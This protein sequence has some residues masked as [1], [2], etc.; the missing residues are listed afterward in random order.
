MKKIF[1]RSSGIVKMA[2]N[3]YASTAS[4]ASYMDRQL[5]TWCRRLGPSAMVQFFR[6]SNRSE[7][8]QIVATIYEGTVF[9]TSC[10]I[11]GNLVTAV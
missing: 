11:S 6:R 2:R 9:E 7:E 8:S 5:L 1:C 4:C 10:S 3:F